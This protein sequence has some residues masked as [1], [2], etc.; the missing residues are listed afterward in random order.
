MVPADRAIAEAP[1]SISHAPLLGPEKPPLVQGDGLIEVGWGDEEE[2]S[3]LD[4]ESSPLILDEPAASDDHEAIRAWNTWAGAQGRVPEG[5]APVEVHDVTDEDEDPRAHFVPP[6][7]RA[8]EGQ[9][10]AP[11]G[12]LFSRPRSTQDRDSVD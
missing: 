5:S 1:A 9:D 10:F 2:A 6:N 4:L 12:H 8:E 11:F 3:A 7:L